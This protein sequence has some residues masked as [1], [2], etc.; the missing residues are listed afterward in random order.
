MVVPFLGTI[1]TQVLVPSFLFNTVVCSYRLLQL[2]AP[3]HVLL[4]IYVGASDRGR[5]LEDKTINNK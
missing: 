2:K 4:T 5:V 3:R 1:S